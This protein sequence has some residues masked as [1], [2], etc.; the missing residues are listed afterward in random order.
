MGAECYVREA[1]TSGR[2][3]N[4]IKVG[5]CVAYDWYFL[6]YALP[7]V[8]ERADIICISVD[9]DRMSWARR[10]FEWDQAGFD[11]LIRS[12]DKAHKVIV[13]EDN[14]HLADLSPAENEVRQRRLMSEKMGAGGWHVQLD[15][16]EYFVDFE[17]FIHYLQQVPIRRSDFNVCCQLVSV[18]KQVAGGYLVVNPESTSSYEFLQIASRTPRFEHGRRN[19]YFNVLSPFVIIH[20]SWARTE[21]EIRQKLLNWGHVGDFDAAT[22]LDFWQ[23]LNEDNYRDFRNF[24]P[25]SPSA[26]PSLKFVEASDVHELISACERDVLPASGQLYRL[27]RN[28]RMISGLLRHSKTLFRKMFAAF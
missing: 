27:M 21:S 16:D 5:F 1:T 22:Y 6:A 13:Y 7:Q 19:G 28:S 26:W 14:F 23:A 3:D 25:I 17:G 20:Q 18:F 2:T 24:H 4:T 11:I 9:K 12:I 8:Y 15:C 10:R